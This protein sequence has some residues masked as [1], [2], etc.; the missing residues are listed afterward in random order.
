MCAQS[1]V[2]T[3]GMCTAAVHRNHHENN[4]GTPMIMVIR[5]ERFRY[6]AFQPISYNITLRVFLDLLYHCPS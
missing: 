5:N 1:S 4:D 3:F 6:S 2:S